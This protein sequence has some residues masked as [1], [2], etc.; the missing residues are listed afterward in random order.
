MTADQGKAVSTMHLDQERLAE[1]SRGLHQAAQP[2]TALQ[3]WID[4]ALDGT[5]SEHEYKSMMKH[6]REESQRVL[7][8]FDRVRESARLQQLPSCGLGVAASS[9]VR[10]VLERFE[11]SFNAAGV[12][13]V[14]HALRGSDAANDLGGSSQNH[15]S[16]ALSLIISSLFPFIKRGDKIELSMK[17]EETTVSIDVLVPKCTRANGGF[18]RELN[19]N[20]PL[21]DMARSLLLSAGGTITL[22]ERG[23]SVQITLPKTSQ[24]PAMQDRQVT[25][26]LHV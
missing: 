6:A 20:I 24:T 5:H 25:R 3:G 17:P 10:V 18:K 4:L 15:A 2:L 22:G 7:G 21:L 13:V 12:T 26:W 11:S 1:I 23:L 14:F 16:T 19:W 9:M 8:C